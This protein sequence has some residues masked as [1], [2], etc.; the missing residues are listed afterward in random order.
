MQFGSHAKIFSQCIILVQIISMRFLFIPFVFVFAII[1]RAQVINDQP[2]NAVMMLVGDSIYTVDNTSASADSLEP[3][4][5]PVL[6]DFTCIL[7]WCNDALAVE[8]SV[9]YTF[10]APDNGAVVISTCNDSNTV[11]TQLAL[12]QVG[13]CNDYS[14]FDLIAANDDMLNG[15]GAGEIYSSAI[16]TDNLIPGQLY[17]IQIDG[18]QADAGLI[19]INVTPS[20]PNSLVNFI[21]NSGDNALDSLEIWMNGQLFAD[22]FLYR[23]C[24]GFMEVVSGDSVY[25]AIC[26]PNSINDSA[27]IYSS[28]F[29][30]DASKDYIMVLDGIFSDSGYITSAATQLQFFQRENAMIISDSIAHLPL[31]FFHG[32]T[33]APAIDI[34]DE[35]NNVWVDNLAY[36]EFSQDYIYV[37]AENT[38]VNVNLANGNPLMALCGQFANLFPG[39]FTLVASGFASPADNSNGPSPDMMLVDHFQ[40]I[41]I[42][43][44]QGACPIPLNDDLCDA[45]ELAVN[46]PPTSFDNSFATVQTGEV[47]CFN[48]PNND[49]ES[50]CLNGWCDGTLDNTLWFYFVAPSDSQVVVSTCFDEAFDTQISVASV[51]DCADFSTVTY[52]A[53]NDDMEGGCGGGNQYAS[54]IIMINSLIPDDIYY[55]QLDGYDGATGSGQIQV[56]SSLPI[57]ISNPSI[58]SMSFYPNP[59]SDYIIVRG[60][61]KMKIQMYDTQSRLCFNDAVLSGS[62][63]SIQEFPAGIYYL[64][65]ESQGISISEKI[66]VE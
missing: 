42:P 29:S 47:S 38:T 35:Q 64:R 28:V 31:L 11:D 23:T 16:S 52:V 27:V 48:L 3:F 7:S 17:Y 6:P 46:A 4:P 66:V 20:Q 32:V 14:S 5:V 24:T 49:P 65:M 57:G 21:H 59:A 15:C 12:W 43:L 36:G 19:G 58:E 56:T 26:A 54:N 9:W 45:A 40:G 51:N 30:F 55:I 1:G 53:A 62:A 60:N 44:N 8:N 2:C 34:A 61:G 10:I 41:F 25:V 50:D 22:D 63:I 37:T 13:N 39:A 18:W 33:D